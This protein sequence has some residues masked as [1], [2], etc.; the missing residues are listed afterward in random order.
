[1]SAREPV[2]FGFTFPSKRPRS[3][4][5]VHAPV[6]SQVQI[7]TMERHGLGPVVMVNITARKI[8]DH[9]RDKPGADAASAPAVSTL[10]RVYHGLLMSGP[11]VGRGMVIFRT[12]SG[13]RMVTTPVRRVLQIPDSD[14]L[15]VETDNSVYRITIHQQHP[16]VAA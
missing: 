1:M 16:S 13:Q 9:G 6:D 5:R 12:P 14:A 4:S 11:C 10:G 8:R 2:S 15:Y 3:F 7:D